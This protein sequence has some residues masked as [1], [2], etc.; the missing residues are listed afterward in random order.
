MPTLTFDN[1]NINYILVGKGEPLIL[2]H[3]FGTKLQ[4]W[5][6]QIEF[7][8]KKM[9][10]IALDNRGVGKSSRP[11]YPYTMDMLVEDI[12]NLLVHLK[13]NE[14]IHLCGISMGGMIVQH[15][16]LKY[17]EKLKTLILCATS[18]KL[19][20][21]FYHLVNGL[22]EME[23]LGPKEKILELCPFVFSRKFQRKLRE[24]KKLFNLI[25]NDAF[26][27]APINDP[28][29]IKDYE[30][31]AYAIEEHDTSKILEQI[32][33]PTLIFGATKDRLVPLHHQKALQEKIDNSRLEIIKGCGHAFT[34]ENP[35]YV[36]GLIWNFIKKNHR[37]CN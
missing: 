22:K 8:K 33:I 30:N 12:N 28:T 37:L 23:S 7:F 20:K 13:I 9:K 32:K 29:E 10:V 5:H 17:P 2:V 27:I 35:D 6:F 4:G 21:G 19:D 3:G 15:F 1:I 14:P 24:D 16:A 31:Q 11:N 25:K 26:F 36:N 18:E 34:I